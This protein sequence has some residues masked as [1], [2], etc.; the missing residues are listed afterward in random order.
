MTTLAQDLGGVVLLPC[1]WC[2]EELTAVR[3]SEG[4]TFRWRKVDGCCTDGP[5]VRHDTMADDQAAAEIDSTSRA[6]AAWNTRAHSAEIAGALRDAERYR[7]LRM[8]AKEQLLN[9]KAA[10]SEWPDMRTYWRIPTLICSG[11]VGGF[12]DFDAAIDAAMQQGGG[13]GEAAV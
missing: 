2:G 12:I 11:P 7:W 5:E 1:P 8:M 3:V 9:P 6:I 10:G 4:S 13:G